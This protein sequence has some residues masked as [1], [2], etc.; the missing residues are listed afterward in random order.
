METCTIFWLVGP[1]HWKQRICIIYSNNMRTSLHFTISRD[2]GFQKTEQHYYDDEL[3]ELPLYFEDTNIGWF[4]R[5]AP[6]LVPLYVT[7][8]GNMYRRTDDELSRTNNSIERWHCS[9]QGHLFVPH[10]T[11][12]KFL[13]APQRQKLQST[14]SENRRRLSKLLENWSSS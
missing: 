5:N 13:K 7:D 2:S 14:H 6:R 4:M 3:D 10:T 11:L 8:N 1:L 12:W 9:F